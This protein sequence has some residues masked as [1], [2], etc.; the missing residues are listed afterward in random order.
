M[1]L[2]R[3]CHMCG[4]PVPDSQGQLE[5]CPTMCGDCLDRYYVGGRGTTHGDLIDKILFWICMGWIALCGVALH[6]AI[7][8]GFVRCCL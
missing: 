2:S 8:F 6:A 4:G 7:W 3:R 1:T 5:G